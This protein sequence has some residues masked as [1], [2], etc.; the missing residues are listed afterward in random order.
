MQKR[1]FL[2]SLILVITAM[3]WGSSFV[4]CKHGLEN[5]GP[6]TLGASRMF[7]AAVT[8]AVIA[9]L[10]DVKQGKLKDPKAGLS[11]EE[12]RIK[13]KDTL[14]GGL[15]CGLALTFSMTTQSMGMVWTT[16]GK[17]GFITAMYMVWVPVL[18][19]PFLK[20]KMVH[21]TVISV[22]MGAVGMYLLCIDEKFTMGKGEV[23][24]LI[25]S[26]GYAAH[27]LCCDKYVKRG[28]PV[29]IACLQSFAVCIINLV[30]ALIFEEPDVNAIIATGTDI[31]YSGVLSGGLGFLGQLIGQQLSSDATVATLLMSLESVFS[32]IFGAILLHERMLPKELIGCIIIFAAVI[33]IQ[34]PQK[35]R[36]EK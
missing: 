6:Y 35:K 2:G 29:K 5:L 12:F 33:L 28:N 34:I 17:S 26:F 13:K 25:C 22:I 30:L 1:S 27:I 7:L 19:I 18:S 20:T 10:M 9:F 36:S 11:E 24:V 31:I 21:R 3:V 8:L 23:L 16:A 15:F 32:V 4:F 14:W